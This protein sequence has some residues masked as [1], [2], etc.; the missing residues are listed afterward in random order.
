M[1]ER[2]AKCLLPSSKPNLGLDEEGLCSACRSAEAKELID[3]D[4]R[5]EQLEGILE[6]Y[7]SKDGSNY[8]CIIPVSGG[9]DSTYQTLKILEMGYNPLCV[10]FR[11]CKSTEL[12]KRNLEN[13]IDLGVDHVMISPRPDVYKKLFKL[14]FFEITST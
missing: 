2:C 8:D 13:L 7:K 4:A 10:T 9:K 12:G 6:K 1:L 3:W 14:G 5:F 11:P